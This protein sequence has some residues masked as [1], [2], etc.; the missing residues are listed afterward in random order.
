L[1]FIL[2]L[3]FFYLTTTFRSFLGSAFATTC[4][5]FF[6]S[7]FFFYVTST[8]RSFLGSAFAAARGATG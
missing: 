5:F 8:F 1:F 2:S 6:L 4:L 3:F 7:L